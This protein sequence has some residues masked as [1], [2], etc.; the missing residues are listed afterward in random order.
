MTSSTAPSPS[1]VFYTSYGTITYAIHPATTDLATAAITTAATALWYPSFVPM[2]LQLSA[3]MK[4]RELSQEMIT[5]ASEI[6]FIILTDDG[7]TGYQLGARRFN[8]IEKYFYLLPCHFILL[9]V[10]I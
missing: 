9:R 5:R 4:P 1:S 2:L 10:F 8:A 7:L 6:T 3:S